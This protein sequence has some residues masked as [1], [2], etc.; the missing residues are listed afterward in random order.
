M[1]VEKIRKGLDP[2]LEFRCKL[3]NKQV[4][5]AG[6]VFDVEWYIWNSGKAKKVHEEKGV[7]VIT[8]GDYFKVDE[9]ELANDLKGLN[10]DVS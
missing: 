2:K 6:A 7:A 3:T 8:P 4:S 9:D 5:P 10:L 1:I